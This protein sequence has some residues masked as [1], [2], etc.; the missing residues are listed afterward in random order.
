[1]IIAV[2][3][4]AIMIAPAIVSGASG[5]KQVRGY[6]WDNTGRDLEGADVTV[7]IRY[8]DTSL[9]S[10]LSDT[11]DANGY[12]S[13][14][15]GPSDWDIGNTI[16]VISTYDSNQETNSTSANANPFQWVNITYPFGIPEFGSTLGILVAGGF[17]GAVSIAMLSRKKRQ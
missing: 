15:F 7:N 14:T 17:L 1:M 5:P 2:A 6:I 9:R 3:V 11:S 13:V 4:A 10:T 16:E 12:Y 8:P